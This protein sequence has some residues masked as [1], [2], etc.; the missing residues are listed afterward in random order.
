M[1]IR[2]PNKEKERRGKKR[3]PVASSASRAR[4]ADKKGFVIVIPYFKDDGSVLKEAHVR[5]LCNI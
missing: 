4:Q 3:G 1:E 5:V 2:E